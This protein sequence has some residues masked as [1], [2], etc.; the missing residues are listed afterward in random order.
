MNL[1]PDEHPVKLVHGAGTDE[2]VIEEIPLYEIDRSTHIGLLTSLYL[3]AL[4]AYSS[5]ETLQ[6]IAA[7]LRAPEGCPW[8]QKQT[9]QSMRPHLMEE[10]Y[11]LLAAIDAD[12]PTKVREELGD[13]LLVITMLMQI[14]SEDCNLNSAA[15]FPAIIQKLIHRHPHVFADLDVDGEETVLQNWE[16]L[17]AEER[18]LNGE[19][20]KYL[21]DGVSIAL[22]A[23]TQAQEYQGRAAR[24]GFDWC[25]IEGVID[26]VCEEVDEF[27]DADGDEDRTTELGDLFFALVNLARWNKIDA[28]S[29]L[30][31]ANIRFRDRFGFIEKAVLK[32]GKEMSEMSLDELDAL[33]DAAKEDLE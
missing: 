15:V 16:K 31:E 29:A 7:H 10:A 21:L 3:P 25:E 1:Y 9:L 6:E 27:R 4:E 13:L 24:V 8:D 5:F 17:K 22:P 2:L 11:E 33:W 26:K 19:T 12:D 20:D 32:Q 23:L 14:A 30:R 18:E 28:E